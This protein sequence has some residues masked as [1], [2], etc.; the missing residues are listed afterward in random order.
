MLSSIGGAAFTMLS[1][2]GSAAFSM[3]PILNDAGLSYKL[4]THA[5]AAL[6]MMFS[7]SQMFSGKAR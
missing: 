2:P 6:P 1:T 7:L 4:S 5:G 3:L